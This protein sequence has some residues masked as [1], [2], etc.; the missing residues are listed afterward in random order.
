[1]VP[2]ERR[3]SWRMH[4]V[5][6]GETLAV[7]GKRY[8]TTPGTIAAAN[9]IQSAVPAVGD[10][11]LIPAAYHETA[12]AQAGPA[13]R[14]KSHQTSTVKNRKATTHH[15]QATGSR[16]RVNRAAAFPET[17]VKVARANP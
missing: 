12:T 17:S 10:R 3:A 8:Q 1:M 2:E 11:L 7:I 5:A 13:K 4:I 6:D 16:S 9:H 15:R 14:S